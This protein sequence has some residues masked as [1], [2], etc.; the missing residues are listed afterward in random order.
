MI[1]TC[2]NFFLLMMIVVFLQLDKKLA[3]CLDLKIYIWIQIGQIAFYTMYPYYVSQIN[4]CCMSYVW[5]GLSFFLLILWQV[6][7]YFIA[8]FILFHRKNLSL[9]Y[10]LI[11]LV[12]CILCLKHIIIYIK[13]YKIHISWKMR[14]NSW[15]SKTCFSTKN[16]ISPR[17]YGV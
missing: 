10:H 8:L 11:Y 3:C 15:A 1:L 13:L 6:L 16:P 7:F 17:F 2:V 12:H 9:F 14:L 4:L 5:R